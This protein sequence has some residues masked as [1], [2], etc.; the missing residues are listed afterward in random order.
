MLNTA[1]QGKPTLWER[2]HWG[3]KLGGEMMVDMTGQSGKGRSHKWD[4][5]GMSEYATAVFAN[6]DAYLSSLKD[7]DLEREINLVPFGFP[8][9]MSLGTFL[10]TMLLGTTYAHTGEISALKGCV[11]AKGYPF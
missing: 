7:G 2:D 9:N 6:T 5:K 3:A 10:T 4:P 8:N 1:V 11:G